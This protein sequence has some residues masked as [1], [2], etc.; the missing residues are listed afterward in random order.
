MHTTSAVPLAVAVALN[1]S[2]RPAGLV[3]VPDR[4]SDFTP[5][6]RFSVSQELTPVPDS[7]NGIAMQAP[8]TRG[9]S[10]TFVV[11]FELV[12]AV[13]VKLSLTVQ[14][15]G[16]VKPPPVP[17]LSKSNANGA[18]NPDPDATGVR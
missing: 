18:F 4:A 10:N 6:R 14:V 16:P 12:S 5:M 13:G 2:A 3:S 8:P 17:Q 9:H 11:P 1:D 7:V 15:P